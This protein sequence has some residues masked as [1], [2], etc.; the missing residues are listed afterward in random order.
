MPSDIDTETKLKLYM[1]IVNRY[2]DLISKQEER[3]ISEIRM[4]V[5]PYY[6]HIR[7]IRAKLLSDFHPYT[8]E[9]DFMTATQRAIN[10][11]K[12]IK[13]VKF[14]LTFWMSFEEI[15]EL[16]IAGVMDKA[17]LLAAILRSLESSEVQVIVTKSERVFVGFKWKGESYLVAPE[18]GSMLA[19]EDA[20]KVFESDPPSY[21]FSDLAYESYEES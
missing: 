4:R 2:K 13:T 10:H 9:R 16:R 14:L 15:S 21:S 6:D 3:S 7:S 1:L 18:S 8:A 19:G 20:S 12:G 17:L 5:S 11:I